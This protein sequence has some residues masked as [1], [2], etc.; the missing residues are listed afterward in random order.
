MAYMIVI[1]ECICCERIFGFNPNWVPSVRIEG[2]RQP[3]CRDCVAKA[4]L[5]RSL[6]GTKPIPVHPDAYEPEPEHSN[7]D[8]EDYRSEED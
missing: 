4:N 1:G 2:V 3:I 7:D 5:Q 8:Y 6:V